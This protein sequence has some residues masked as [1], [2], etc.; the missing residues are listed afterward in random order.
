MPI[1]ATTAL[2]VG[3]SVAKGVISSNAAGNAA[4]A[5]ESAAQQAA[6]FNNNV[7]QSDQNNLNPFIQTGQSANSELGGLLGLNGNTNA[8]NAFQTFLNSTPYKFQ[9]GQ[10]EQAI[11]TQNANQYGAGATAKAL[12]NYA[13]GQA[14][15]ALGNYLSQLSG[16]NTSG[17]NAAGTLG[18]LGVSASQMNAN[19]LM[20]KANAYGAGQVNQANA[21]NGAING[22]T[23]S[24]SSYAG[25]GS[26]A[27]SS[28]GT[29]T[30]PSSQGI[31]SLNNQG[32]GVL[33][34]M[35]NFNNYGISNPTTPNVGY[36]P[37]TG[38][39]EPSQYTSPQG[40]TS[41][42]GQL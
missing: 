13:Q 31:S 35:P 36:L 17:Q 24:L 7:W 14:G 10:G 1:G 2:A 9:L 11:S 22:V 5:G 21:W 15:S 41:V 34:T 27:N 4:K 33:T 30:L 6:D 19:D 8:Q 28:F 37:V 20:N 12:N 39:T 29:V 32:S 40:D 26:G 18:T 23:G 42:V 3:G 16:L 25:G 38:Y